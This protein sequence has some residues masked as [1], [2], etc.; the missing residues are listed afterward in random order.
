MKSGFGGRLVFAFVS[1]LAVL[2]SSCGAPAPKESSRTAS[3]ISNLS[4][5][6]LSAPYAVYVEN[7]ELA[8]GFCPAGLR[9]SRETCTESKIAMPFKDFADAMKNLL[10]RQIGPE[11]AVEEALQASFT[12]AARLD[13]QLVE[14][15]R[16]DLSDVRARLA[17]VVTEFS[18]RIGAVELTLQGLGS[19]IAQIESSLQAKFDPDLR[20]QLARLHVDKQDAVQRLNGLR[21]ELLRQRTEIVSA[22]SGVQPEFF[23][24]LQ[25]KRTVLR[26]TIAKQIAAVEAYWKKSSD[27]SQILSVIAS[28]RVE[29][30]FKE[31]DGFFKA[32]EGILRLV[33]KALDAWIEGSL[34]RKSK[35]PL[36]EAPAVYRTFEANRDLALKQIVTDLMRLRPEILASGCVL[37][38]I[39]SS[40]NGMNTHFDVFCS[41]KNGSFGGLVWYGCKQEKCWLEVGMTLKSLLFPRT[42]GKPAPAWKINF[43]S[44]NAS[45]L[46]SGAYPISTCKHVIPENLPASAIGTPATISLST[47]VCEMK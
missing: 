32:Y 15:S 25:R 8:A 3:V 26:E 37:N 41:G 34:R 27:L 7:G 47:S 13:D 43:I 30:E 38:N 46:R 5:S 19:Q 28:S 40:G 17:A 36:Q 18:A 24:E 21:A 35:I 45:P 2:F 9:P 11:S 44:R 39:G 20:A 14:F 22:Q 1:G 23:A 6:A 33:P 10:V 4:A 42:M 16:G 31:G 12:E 29:M